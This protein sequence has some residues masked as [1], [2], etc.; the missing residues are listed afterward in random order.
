MNKKEFLK[1]LKKYPDDTEIRLWRWTDNGSEYYQ[2]N[3]SISN[4]PYIH[5]ETF[6]LVIGRLIRD[7]RKK[8]Q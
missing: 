5:P 6:E 7:N 3:P 8:E 2:T 1:A 4:N